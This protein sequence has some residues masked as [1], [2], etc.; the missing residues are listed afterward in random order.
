[1]MESQF[2]DGKTDLEVG[3]PGGHGG[4]QHQRVR[5]SGR[6]VEMVLG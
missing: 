4:G 2:D 5:V 6:A 3:G 1:M